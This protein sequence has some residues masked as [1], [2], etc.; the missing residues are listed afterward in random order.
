MTIYI[1]INLENAAFDDNPVEEIVNILRQTINKVRK[2]GVDQTFWLCD[3]NGNKI[4]EYVC[5]E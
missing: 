5:E 2:L 1:D 3:S 4:G